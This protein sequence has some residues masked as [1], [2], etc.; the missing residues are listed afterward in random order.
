LKKTCIIFYQHIV[1]EYDMCS[2]VKRDIEELSEGRVE[3]R[4]FSLDFEWTEACRYAANA[5]LVA[6]LLPW[7]RLRQHESLIAP[8]VK[9]NPN[10]LLIDFD[11]EQTGSLVSMKAILP[12]SEFA[13]TEVYHLAW[14]Q[15]F[16]HAMYECGVPKNRVTISGNARLDTLSKPKT[17]RRD[18]ARLYSLDESKVWILFAETRSYAVAPSVALRQE[19][20]SCGI[21]EQEI[22]EYIDIQVRSL[23]KT[24]DQVELIDDSFFEEYEFIYRLHPGHELSYRIDDRIRVISDLPI[25]EWL[26]SCQLYLTWGSTSAFEAS[27]VGIPVVIHEPFP[28]KSKFKMCGL[29]E[30]ETIRSIEELSDLE[31]Q[32]IASEQRESS[33]HEKYLGKSGSNAAAKI[34]ETVLALLEESPIRASQPF[35]DPG[36]RL[37]KTLFELTTRLAVSSGLFHAF[38]YPR[39]AYNEKRDIPYIKGNLTL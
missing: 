3:A 23:K 9:L 26:H 13:K 20:L 1:R 8:F 35:D 32:G 21:T 38:R 19:Q 27:A 24:L 39:S 31:L 10:V 25:G 30:F 22:K 5:N 12:Q 34:S 17:T 29:D 28:Y 14:T 18:L 37:R 4:I 33:I 6:V 36:F 15:Y 11:H 7:M 2:R 16:A